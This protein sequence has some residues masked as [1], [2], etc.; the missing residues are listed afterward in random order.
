L[1][2]TLLATPL[3][4]QEI[5]QGQSAAVRKAITAPVVTFLALLFL[6]IVISMAGS[7]AGANGLSASPSM[8][9]LMFAGTLTV[10]LLL[11]LL[12]I[13][14]FGLW[15]SLRMKQPNYAAPLTIL[16]VVILPS[17]GCAACCVATLVTD[18]IFF[19]VGYNRLQ[20]DLRRT[21]ARPHDSQAAPPARFRL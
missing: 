4:S 5:I 18:L 1:L 20:E 6:P 21:L 19:L 11:D 13:H 12:A 9:G 8:P 16:C 14:W 15:L 3:S 17:A 2:E 10:G 7:L